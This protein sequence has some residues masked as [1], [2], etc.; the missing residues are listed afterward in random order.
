VSR[1]HPQTQPA[2][3]TIRRLNEHDRDEIDRLSQVDSKTVDLAA[4][5]LGAEIEGRLLAAISVPSGEVAADPFSRTAEVRS[6]LELRAAQLRRRDGL[7]GRR[8]RGALSGHSRASL[9]GSPPGA[10]GRLL[11]LLPRF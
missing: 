1:Q 7:R 2:A 4:P 11:T 9:A 6:L 10:G 8:L 5:V 3:V